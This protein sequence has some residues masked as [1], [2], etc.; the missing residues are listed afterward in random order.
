MIP[1]LHE[2]MKKHIQNFIEL[3]DIPGGAILGL[4]SLVVLGMSIASFVYQREIPNNVKEIFNWILTAFAASKT[5]KTIFGKIAGN[6]GKEE[7][8]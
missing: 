1:S 5:L 4:W 8:K 7:V 2:S 6:P 3:F